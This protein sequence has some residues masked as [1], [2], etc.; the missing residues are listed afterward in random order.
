MK[1]TEPTDFS[2]KQNSL[3]C[4]QTIHQLHLDML[5]TH[6]PSLIPPRDERLGECPLE[7]WLR[8]NIPSVLVR[9]VLRERKMDKSI[10]GALSRA[11]ELYFELS[12]S[13]IRV[14]RTPSVHH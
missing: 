8:G 13:E 10:I 6:S 14:L 1:G 2:F 5:R 9:L 3:E 12:P 4:H 11:L 7:K